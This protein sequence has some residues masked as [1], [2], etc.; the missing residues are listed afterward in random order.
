MSDIKVKTY[1]LIVLDRSSSMN[2]VR[3]VTI[4]GL[5]EQLDSIRKT[6]E[7]HPEQ[8]QIV[9]FATFSDTVD[10]DQRWNKPIL[11]VSNFTEE[12]YNPQ[13]MT[14][15]HD[16]IGISIN[17]MKNEIANDLKNRSAN[18]MVMIFTDGQE[19]CSSEFNRNT[20]KNLVKEVKDSG[21]WTVSFIGC[22][23]DVFEVA[24]GYGIDRGDT[25]SY[26]AGSDGTRSAFAKMSHSRS[27]RSVA[28][29]N[30][31]SKNL[32]QTSSIECMAAINQ[33]GHFFDNMDIDGPDS[34]IDNITDMDVDSDE[35]K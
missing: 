20:S 4:N 1:N 11:E 3:Q 21:M 33:N 28:Y 34:A 29:S 5:N 14:A 27:A 17:K 16:A 31:L 19:N 9:C 26:S 8:E 2:S 18:V 32:D 30:I 6:Q 15:L 10:V 12:D 24:Q 22:G 35:E 25:L 13:G 23:D 7:E